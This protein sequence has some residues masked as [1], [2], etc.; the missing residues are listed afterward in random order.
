MIS[1]F[2]ICRTSD[3][4]LM[5]DKYWSKGKC[6]KAYDCKFCASHRLRIK[7]LK[8]N[9]RK[10]RRVETKKLVYD[11]NLNWEKIKIL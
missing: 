3:R 5:L 4:C 10:K 1:G 7:R 2:R 6:R 11:M 8:R 9:K